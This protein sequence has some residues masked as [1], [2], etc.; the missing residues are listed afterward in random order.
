[1]GRCT[2]VEVTHSAGQQSPQLVVESVLLEACRHTVV[3][4]LR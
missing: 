1:M 4:V 3:Y 2:G